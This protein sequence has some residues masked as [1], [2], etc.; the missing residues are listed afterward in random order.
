VQWNYNFQRSNAL[1]VCLLSASVYLG[2]CQQSPFKAI[3]CILKLPT[4]V[5]K[6]C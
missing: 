6:S 4:W 2:A 1:S 3:K 5:V